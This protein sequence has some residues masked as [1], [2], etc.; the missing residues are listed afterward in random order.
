MP[1]I[2]VF[3]RLIPNVTPLV[4]YKDTLLILYHLL[5]NAL[6]VSKIKGCRKPDL[7]PYR[8]FKC[9]ELMRQ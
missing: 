3:R 1:A 7:H 8:S 2:V 5:Y 9:L 4:G 6:D